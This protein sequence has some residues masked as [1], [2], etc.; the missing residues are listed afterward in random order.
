MDQSTHEIRTQQWAEMIRQC[1][2][3]GLTRKE[4]CRQNGISTKTF[5]YRQKQIRNEAYC[6]TLEK[7][8]SG[9]LSNR[10]VEFAEAVLPA[11]PSSSMEQPSDFQPDAIIRT[12]TL[13][14]EVSNRASEEILH[15]IR[16]VI[17]HAS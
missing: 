2:A 12:P 5:Y 1:N 17:H 3:S 6:K 9:R 14:I 16:T 11:A 8:S 13:T 7:S 10:T 15:L 4:W